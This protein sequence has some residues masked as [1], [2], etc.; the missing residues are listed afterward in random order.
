[1]NQNIE[2][3]N[4]EGNKSSCSNIGEA[5]PNK[6]SRKTYSNS[7]GNA[8]KFNQ[9]K[10]EEKKN[11]EWRPSP[12]T[13]LADFPE[14]SIELGIRCECSRITKLSGCYL[15]NFTSR[16]FENEDN[17]KLPTT[18]TDLNSAAEMF[19]KCRNS[20]RMMKP[21]EKMS[22][23]GEMFRSSVVGEVQSTT[24]KRELKMDYRL[25]GNLKVCRA[26]FCFVYNFSL[27][28]LKKLSS[29]YKITETKDTMALQSIRR[30]SDSKIHNLTYRKSED[31]F[32]ENL[33]FSGKLICF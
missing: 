18:V 33:G 19:I 27:S 8:S 9:Q 3:I 16:M 30:W 20:T 17:T 13:T 25:N 14:M 15:E 4:K 7:I 22:F 21:A 31:I 5:Q 29:L 6:R 1:M 23:L 32:K 2:L 11:L 26:V 12:P 28:Q 24:G 10:N